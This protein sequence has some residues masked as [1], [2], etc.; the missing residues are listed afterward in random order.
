MKNK[1][2]FKGS[3]M[4]NKN[5]KLVFV[6]YLYYKYKFHHMICDV[7]VGVVGHTRYLNK[8]KAMPCL[9]ISHS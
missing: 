8:F 7:D 3:D 1:H 9:T 5:E 6:Q 4:L 2:I